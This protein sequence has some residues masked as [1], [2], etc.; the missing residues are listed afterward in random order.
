MYMNGVKSQPVS[1][2]DELTDELLLVHDL[3]LGEAKVCVDLLLQRVD[4]LVKSQAFS[5]GVN[6]GRLLLDRYVLLSGRVE[7][8][9]W[10]EGGSDY[11]GLN[12]LLLMLRRVGLEGVLLL[13][14][15]QG[16][17]TC[18]LFLMEDLLLSN[19]VLHV[20]LSLI[21]IRHIKLLLFILLLL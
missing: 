18:K 6:L 7:D 11:L 15:L 19:V 12:G 21:D 10:I 13:L 16:L 8:W 20:R 4:L 9:G 14:E 5:S 3:H 1:L 2:G 17:K